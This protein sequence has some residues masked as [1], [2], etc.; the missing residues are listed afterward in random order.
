MQFREIAG[1]FIGGI[2]SLALVATLFNQNST[3]AAV[4]TSFGNAFANDIRAATFQSG[5]SSSSGG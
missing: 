5:G 3:T 2:I 4:A 1:L